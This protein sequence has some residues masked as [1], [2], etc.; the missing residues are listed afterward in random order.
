MPKVGDTAPDFTLASHTGTD[1][2]LSD[3]RGSSHVVLIFYPEDFSPVCSIQV[4]EYSDLRHEF[5]RLDT[6]V[7]GVNRDSVYT[8]RAWAKEYGIAVPLLADMTLSVARAYDVALPER[9]TSKRAVFLVDKD[10]VVRLAHVEKTTGDF[11]LHAAEVLELL[12]ARPAS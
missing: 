8:H 4:P 3:F 6:V 7:L 1:I 9:G 11:T 2:R 5:E 12:Q 10:G